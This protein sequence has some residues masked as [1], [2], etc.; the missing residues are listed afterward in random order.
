MKKGI[1]T[2]VWD[3]G[4]EVSSYAELNEETG[5]V[6]AEIVDVDDLNLESLDREYFTDDKGTEFTI[7]PTC[8][9]YIMV[10]RLF[11]CI[12]EPLKQREVCS[13]PNCES[14]L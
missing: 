2:S 4:D 11:D 8:H 12:D 9:S 7:C 13:D 5:E 3:G 6:I 14:N 1:F 10:N